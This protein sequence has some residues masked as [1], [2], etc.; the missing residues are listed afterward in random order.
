M[1]M[2][3]AASDAKQNATAIDS[4]AVDRARNAI[5][6][7]LQAAGDVDLSWIS[8]APSNNGWSLAPDALRFITRLVS[9]LRPNHVLEFGSGL[10]TRVLAR[11]CAILPQPSALSSVDHDPEFGSLA[12]QEC[13]KDPLACSD[14]SMQIAPIVARKYCDKLLPIYLW[15]PDR[16][17][18]PTLFDLVIVDGPPVVLGGREGQLYQAMDFAQSGTVMLLDDVI[19]P[20]EQQALNH[21]K[22]NYGD[23]IEIIHLA[24]FTQGMAAVIVLEAV[25]S[26]QLPAH[27]LGLTRREIQRFF[28]QE[29]VCIVV[30][31]D[32][33]REEIAGEYK[34]LPF[35]E[36]EG[37][38]WGAPPDDY[39]A[40][41]ELERMRRQ[42]ADFIVFG[43]PFFWWLKHYQGLSSHLRSSFDCV[44]ENDRL[45][46]FDLHGARSSANSALGT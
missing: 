25:Y 23:A 1:N 34:T 39:T 38:N 28:Q 35:I 18:S 40:I 33:W 24:G 2:N 12:A 46:V 19:R 3:S 10:S 9:I 13:R 26:S 27:R 15:Q 4:D 30:G 17:A 29:H 43:G 16:F 31:D 41:R 36:N 21:W 45:V 14:L 37:Q 42:G 20:E 32:W 11:A 6:E 5:N 7:A 44:L 8:P 22:D